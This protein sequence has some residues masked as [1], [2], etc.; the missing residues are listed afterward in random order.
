MI[1]G[2]DVFRDYFKDY[3][4]NYVLIGGSA[5]FI[6]MDNEGLDYRSTKDLD[7]VICAEALNEDFLRCFWNFINEGGYEI[8][9]KANGDKCLYRFTKPTNPCFPSMLE[10]LSRSSE[11]L[12]ERA[13]GSII[14][15]TIEEE[16]VSLSAILLDEDYYKF[17]MQLK[18]EIDDI[19]IVDERC[20]IPLKIRA[21]IDLTKRK[22]AGENIKE[23]DIRKHKNDVYRLSQLLTNKSI[24]DVPTVIREDIKYFVSNVKD[25][26]NILIN[27]KIYGT[28]ISE[29]CN[30]LLSVYCSK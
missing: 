26:D 14:P 4:E 9:Q 27:L 24:E 17:I 3:K 13:S 12:D 20:I 18:M 23:H 22:E 7:I 30:Q 6:L 1:R 16:I 19:I 10:I 15:M 5:C 8:R 11:V 28:S 21:W 29:I 25:E 2:L